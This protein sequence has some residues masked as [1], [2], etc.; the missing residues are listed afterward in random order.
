MKEKRL[1]SPEKEFYKPIKR[2]GTQITIELKKKQRG[3]SILKED[4]S[5]LGLFVAN[6]AVKKEA[7]SYPLTNY[8]LALCTAQAHYTNHARNI[9]LS[10]KCT[11]HK[12]QLMMPWL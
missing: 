11:I 8:A 6:Y 7:F 12:I 9:Y 2:S 3:I 10:T 5:A 1:T 4:W